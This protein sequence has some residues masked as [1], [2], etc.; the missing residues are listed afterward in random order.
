MAPSS[1]PLQGPISPALRV[2]AVTSGKGGVGKTNL[3]TNLAVEMAR[4]GRRVLLVDADLGLANVDI[5]LGLTPQATLAEVLRGE[6]SIHDVLLTGPAGIRVLPAASGVAEITHLSSEDRLRLLGELD[7]LESEFDVVLLDTGAGISENVLF[8]ASA[9]QEIV[10]VAIPEPTSIADAYALMK[11][12]GA[13]H[14]ARRFRLVVNMVRSAEEGR[15]VYARLSDVAGRFLDVSI[16]YLGHI[17]MDPAVRR[18][19]TQR[20][21][22]CLVFPEAPASRAIL[23]LAKRIL[24]S[25]YSDGSTGRQQLFWRRLMAEEG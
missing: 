1:E 11:V 6:C 23:G 4:L 2:I 9:A 19:V 3:V 12:L 14:A 13:R 8:F 15:D 24:M 18:A 17:L 25:R 22:M 10:V 5:V 20:R 21:P 16:D 7:Q